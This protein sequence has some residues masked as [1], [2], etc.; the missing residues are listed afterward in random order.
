MKSLGLVWDLTLF[1]FF[2]GNRDQ[3]AERVLK[4]KYQ[5][6]KLPSCPVWTIRQFVYFYPIILHIVPQPA[7]APPWG[8]WT[9]RPAV[10]RS[11]VSV[12]VC[13]TWLSGTAAPASQAS[14]TF[15]AAVA[16][17]GQFPSAPSFLT[18]LQ[19]VCSSCTVQTLEFIIWFKQFT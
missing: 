15:R 4:N 8:R 9:S 7:P 10:R 12:R 3:R 1:S 17:S 16:V 14:S 2:M 5:Y 18:L 6:L 11:P 19:S 13:Q